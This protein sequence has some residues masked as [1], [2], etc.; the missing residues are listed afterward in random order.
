MIKH[1][2]TG[3]NYENWLKLFLEVSFFPNLHSA[4]SSGCLFFRVAFF[5][6]PFFLVTCF[7]MPFFPTPDTT[8]LGRIMIYF[9]LTFY[10][11]DVYVVVFCCLSL[12]VMVWLVVPIST[13]TVL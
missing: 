7:P 3:F 2:S 8:R 5:P 6:M 11:Q 13:K 9:S 10:R 12:I 4:I 1:I